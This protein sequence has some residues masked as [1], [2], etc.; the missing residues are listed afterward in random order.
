MDLK[1]IHKIPFSLFYTVS[2]KGHQLYTFLNFKRILT[3]RQLLGKII[4]FLLFANFDLYWNF[5][6]ILNAYAQKMEH[7]LTFYKK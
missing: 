5:L 1:G 7:F 3:E 6:Q 4:K 2:S